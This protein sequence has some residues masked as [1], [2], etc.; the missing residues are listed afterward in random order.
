[1][2]TKWAIFEDFAI[3]VDS[4]AAAGLM[5]YATGYIGDKYHI[6]GPIIIFNSTVAIIGLPL[7]GW[8][9]NVGVRYFGVFLVCMGA[10][11]K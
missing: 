5:M 9:E 6:R 4:Y 3:D 7:I 11:S 2:L 1:M 10:N 8:V